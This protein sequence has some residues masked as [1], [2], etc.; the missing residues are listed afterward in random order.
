MKYPD[1]SIQ[2]FVSPWWEPDETRTFRRGQLIKA[3]LPHVSLIPTTLIPTGRT[4]DPRNHSLVKY[5]IRPLQ[6]HNRT[7]LPKLPTAIFPDFQG[8]IYSVYRAK[9]RPALV[10]SVGGPDLRPEIRGRGKPHWQSD[11]TILVAPYYGAEGGAQRAGFSEE[12]ARRA[13]RGEYPNF[14]W[15]ILPLTG[16]SLA[17]SILRFDH[18]QPI[19]KHHDS[20]EQT[21]YC[22]SEKAMVYVDNWIHWLVEGILDE[23]SELFYL[24]EA[25]LSGEFD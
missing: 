8:E 18:I 17:G 19:G 25:F 23:K 2:S 20:Y 15:D 1:D 5:Q 10:I 13:R 24:R 7:P 16:S 14:S 4:D 9:K 22:L 21:G 11:P 12:L 6:I 3:F